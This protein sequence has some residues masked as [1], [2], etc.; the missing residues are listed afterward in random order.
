MPME[1]QL[2]RSWAAAFGSRPAME[3]P[4][5]HEVVN[6]SQLERLVR[7]R[8]GLRPAAPVEAMSA[9]NINR[10]AAVDTD[11][12]RVVLQELNTSVFP[13]PAALMA[14]AVAIIERMERAN[15]PALTFL[16]TVDGTWLADLDGVPWRCYR[17][18]GGSGTPAITTPEDA[19]STARAFGRFARAIDG[20]EL[21]EHLPGYHAFDL[22]V[23][24][25]EHE[26]DRDELGRLEACADTVE[27]LFHMVDRLRLS[28]SYEAWSTVPVRNAHNDAKGP[29]CVVGERGARTVIDLDTTMPGTILNDIG[30]LVRSST[31]Y[32]DDPSPE[33]VMHQIEAVNRGFLAGF[34]GELTDAEQRAGE[35]HA[36][37]FGQDQGCAEKN[38][39]VVRLAKS[40]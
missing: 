20:L 2:V 12:G 30:E 22:R 33:V 28:P 25:L 19:Q 40:I 27:S 3:T 13:D 29:N 39:A 5:G 17:F 6:S 1:G 7:E 37:L 9:G 4:D 34:D 24:A 16:P 36:P 15:L 10:S 31:R 23:G 26:V 38:S 18:I 14:N 11:N 21:A 8:F 35:Q 32:L